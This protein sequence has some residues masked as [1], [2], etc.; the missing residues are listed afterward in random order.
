MTD[1]CSE[2]LM[3]PPKPTELPGEAPTTDFGDLPQVAAKYKHLK[4]RLVQQAPQ[5]PEAAPPTVTIPAP[6]TAPPGVI[7][8]QEKPSR[9]QRAAARRLKE[10]L[11]TER[12]QREAEAEKE[13]E[14]AAMD[15]ES[16]KDLERFKLRVW[17]AKL[18]MGSMAGLIFFLV[19]MYM[20]A[21]VITKSVPDLALFGAIFG[22]LK[23]VLVV[24]IEANK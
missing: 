15:V 22:H 4:E 8:P 17:I 2:C 24:V 10:A 5:A 9:R 14:A 12:A 1:D 13:K 11:D 23:E 18:V 19:G 16:L 21:A 20:Y 7:K 3:E 6:A